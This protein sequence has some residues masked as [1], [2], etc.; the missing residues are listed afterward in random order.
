MELTAEMKEHLEKIGVSLESLS[1]DQK[2]L[3][4]KLGD[5]EGRVTKLEKHSDARVLDLP[6]VED[7]EELK[8]W[9][10]FSICRAIR[11]VMFDEW[12]ITRPGDDE[13]KHCPE[14]GMYLEGKK[15]Q[16]SAGSDSGGGFLVPVQFMPELIEVL[17]ANSVVE[18][19]GATVMDDLTGSPLEIPRQTGGATASWVGENS[20]IVESTLTFGQVTMS[21]HQASALVKMSNRLVRLSN[22][23]IE[24]IVRQDIMREIALLRDLAYLRG[25][26]SVNQPLGLINTAGVQELEVATDGGPITIELYYDMEEALES[27]DALRGTLGWVA[28]PKLWKETRQL[29]AGGSTTT[30]GPFFIQPDPVV[31][32]IRSVLGHTMRTTTQ[33]P[34]NLTKGSGTDLTELIFGNWAD[35]I[36]GTWGSIEIRATD[37]T[38]GAFTDNQ[39]WIRAI[40][41]TDGAVRIPESFVFIND[42]ESA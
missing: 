26:G 3:L 17:K 15:K 13:A 7:E 19:S 30:D 9:G 36:I 18:E 1:T 41:E 28:H 25:S 40:L 14:Y 20:T 23:S 42:L 39:T 22:P 16:Q 24:A 31:G 34:V 2:E 11:G 35:F 32:S 33:I 10:G 38:T 5:F 6:G 37:T 21:P 29:R 12:K 8:K 27:S 4:T